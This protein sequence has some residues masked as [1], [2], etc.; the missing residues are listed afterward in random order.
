MSDFPAL[1]PSSRVFSP[2]GY[3]AADIASLN[4]TES[5][6]RLSSTMVESRLRLGFIGLTEAEM[7]SVLTHYVGQRGGFDAFSLPNDVLSGT[8]DP[9]NFRLPGYAWRYAESPSVIDW[10]CYNR[11]DVEISIVTV[12]PVRFEALPFSAS[13]SVS[14]DAGDAAAANGI[15]ASIGVLIRG[16]RPAVVVSMPGVVA[17]IE[18]DFP[19]PTSTAPPPPTFIRP[20]TPRSA[21]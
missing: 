18:L 4:G 1:V 11:H 9:D 20:T 8:D 12:P 14:L 5:N 17:V 13:I 19:V 15:V 16:G 7:L 10:A 3:P 21:V 6:T 2:G